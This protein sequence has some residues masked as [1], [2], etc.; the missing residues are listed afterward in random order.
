GG[1]EAVVARESVVT[2]VPNGDDAHRRVSGLL[3]G[4][5][6][7][8][9]ADD[10]PEA[11]TSVDEGRGLR[12]SQYATLVRGFHEPFL[13]A[14]DIATEAGDPMTRDPAEIRDDEHVGHALRIGLGDTDLREDLFAE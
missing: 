3:D 14:C 8:L 4:E 10:L 13:E 2:G 12:L 6:H 5:V 7:P 9:P 1:D 11:L